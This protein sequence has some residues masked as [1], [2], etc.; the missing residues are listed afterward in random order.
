MFK[1]RKIKIWMIEFLVV[2]AILAF[3]TILTGNRIVEW[4][5][6]LAV[7]FT[8]GHVSVTDRM[9]EKQASKEKP[10]VECYKWS[11]R[12]LFG[13]EILWL[14]YFFLHQSYAALVGV[15]IF[16]LYPF[17]RRWYRKSGRRI[18]RRLLDQYPM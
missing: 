2:L 11:E 16:L 15:F 17:W 8:F 14:A 9:M 1:G 6:T 10:D 5:G 4:I 18:K 7:L 3:V 12:Y 13:K